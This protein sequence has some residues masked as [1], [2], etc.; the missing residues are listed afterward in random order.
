MP[1]ADS[2]SRLRRPRL[3]AGIANPAQSS[4]FR[5]SPRYTMTA[6]RPAAAGAPAPA[7]GSPSYG[8]YSD[9]GGG[10]GGS[11]APAA[12]PKPS[13]KDFID[14][15]FSYRQAMD[16]YG[17]NGRRIQEFDAETGRLRGDIDRDIKVR[18]E[19]L[20]AD[21]QEESLG[22]A[23]DLAGRGLLRSGGLFQMQEQTNRAGN[24]RRGAID[25]ILTDFISSRGSGRVQQQQQNRSALNER[26]AALTN[27]YAAQYGL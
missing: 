8:A 17:D 26:I 14:N 22:N 12:P 15:D 3:S 7:G 21:L 9:E 11:P 16:E 13:L 23:N 5:K 25:D 2:Y 10:Y 1:T 27:Q 20:D 18:R 4:V 24:Q 6:P 19:D